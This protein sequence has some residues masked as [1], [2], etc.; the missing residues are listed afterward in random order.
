M[1]GLG[2]LRLYEK[3]FLKHPTWEAAIQ[4][5]RQFT[6]QIDGDVLLAQAFARQVSRQELDAI[7]IEVSSWR[8]TCL[9]PG[10]ISAAP[11]HLVSLSVGL[12][13]AAFAVP[14]WA[15]PVRSVCSDRAVSLASI[16]TP[17]GQQT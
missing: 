14:L 10:Y 17:G 4:G 7:P 9:V 5:L 8:P 15:R 3:N 6:Q 1:V 2:I 16:S 12:Q 13:E 11:A